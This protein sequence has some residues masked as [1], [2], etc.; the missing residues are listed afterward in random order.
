MARFVF[1]AVILILF[2]HALSRGIDLAPYRYKNRLLVI[3]APNAADADYR[4]QTAQ[5]QENAEG[6]RDR[7]L[8]ILS[9]TE[10]DGELHRQFKLSGTS[11][12]VLLIGKDGHVV[13][14]ESNPIKSGRLFALIDA[15]PMRQKEVRDANRNGS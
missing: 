3:L 7:D 13:V 6:F 14:T 1:L 12:R 2:S 11:F 15:M 4:S 5:A 9:E 8:I 10:P